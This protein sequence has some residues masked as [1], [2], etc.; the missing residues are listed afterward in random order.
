MFAV[1]VFRLIAMEQF[2]SLDWYFVK[3]N[4]QFA[5]SGTGVCINFMIIMSLNVV[6]SR[7]TG[8]QQTRVICCIYTSMLNKSVVCSFVSGRTSRPCWFWG[9]GVFFCFLM[10]RD[11]SFVWLQCDSSPPPTFSVLML[12]MLSTPQVYEKVAYLL[13]NLGEPLHSPLP[14]ALTLGGASHRVG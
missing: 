3:K 7:Q 5:T 11:S 12:M 2:A 6:G 8:R 14:A 10:L 1:V 13:T 4:W 9:F